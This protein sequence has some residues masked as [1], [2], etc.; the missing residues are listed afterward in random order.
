MALNEMIAQ[1]A[2]FKMPDP[3]EQY[4]RIAQIQQA[5]N[6]NALAQ[7][8]LGTAQRGDVQ[9]NALYRR[10]Q[11]PTF[12]QNNPENLASLAQFG[13]PGITAMKSITEAKNAALTGSKLR[14]D[15]QEQQRKSFSSDLLD[16]GSNPTDEK[17][18]F[19]AKNIAAD[20]NYPPAAKAIAERKFAE[21]IAMP[22]D[23]RK[24][25]LSMSGASVGERTTAAQ[26]Q[27]TNTKPN[28]IERTDGSRKWLEDTNPSSVSYGERKSIDRMQQTPGEIQTASTAGARLEFDKKVQTF[29]ENNPG[30]HIEAINNPDG[31]QRFV[32]VD[33]KT[34]KASPITEAQI[35]AAASPPSASASSPT[36]AA[37]SAALTSSRPYKEP[38]VSEQNAG[39][40]I[41][42]VLRGATSIQN[43][44]AKDPTAL[45]PQIGEAMAT[46]VGLSG[47]AN[48][49]RTEN[50]QKVYGAQRDVI[51]ALLYLATGAAYNKEQLAAQLDTY[52]PQFTDKPANVIEKQQRLVELIN[53]AKTRAGKAWT[54]KM[55]AAMNVL[56]IQSPAP[57]AAVIPSAG[58]G[59]ATVVGN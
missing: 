35:G 26:N 38:T 28:F 41:A 48:A 29:R 21:L 57:S 13:T 27:F 1:G 43:V 12:D 24:E 36:P 33:K 11:D 54:P 59:R 50:R 3:L 6:Q 8:Q 16:L 47:T 39:Y 52:M 32:A 20:P 40:N 22:F 37:S 30:F 5:Q 17:V 34:L 15:I 14:G 31:S 53:D 44:I 18:I 56:N 10:L 51:D 7:Y 9:Q 4:G 45:A 46:S 58:F 42:R 19:L 49:T 25:L 2:Q 55:D 23:K